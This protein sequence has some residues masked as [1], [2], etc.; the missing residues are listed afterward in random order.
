MSGTQSIAWPSLPHGLRATTLGVVTLLIVWALVGTYQ[1]VTL[2]V[3][4]G[5]ERSRLMDGVAQAR[6]LLERRRQQ[7]RRSA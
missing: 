6:A 4:F 3:F 5:T 7:E 1:L 2:T